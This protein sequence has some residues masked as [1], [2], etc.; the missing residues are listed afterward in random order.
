[1]YPLKII[2]SSLG[3]IFISR[4]HSAIWSAVLDRNSRLVYYFGLHFVG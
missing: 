3:C 2:L 4:V 1:M